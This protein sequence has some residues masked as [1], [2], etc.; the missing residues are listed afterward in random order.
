MPKDSR[1]LARSLEPIEDPELHDDIRFEYVG[2]IEAEIVR[3][4]VHQLAT[5]RPVRGTWVH[6]RQDLYIDAETTLPAGTDLW[7]ESGDLDGRYR[8][9]DFDLDP[10]FEAQ[11]FRLDEGHPETKLAG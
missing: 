5:H 7:L 4:A 6:A 9:T 10:T 3:R 2:V 1:M 11:T 8:Y